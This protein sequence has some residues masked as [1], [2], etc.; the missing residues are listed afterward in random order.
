MKLN[1]IIIIEGEELV[2]NKTIL[3][4]E[5]SGLFDEPIDIQEAEEWESRLNKSK[6]PYVL[7]ETAYKK[8]R[9]YMIFLRKQ[10]LTVC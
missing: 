10:D 5:D 9:G 3:L 7:L 8:G 4:D 2:N 6:I 1:D